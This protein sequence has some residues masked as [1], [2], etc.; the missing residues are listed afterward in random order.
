MPALT[1]LNKITCLCTCMYST[2]LP[3][4]LCFVEEIFPLNSRIYKASISYYDLNEF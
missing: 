2:K 3:S 4:V 1:R